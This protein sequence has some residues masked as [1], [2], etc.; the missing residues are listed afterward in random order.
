MVEI[1]I[2]VMVDQCR[3]VRSP[4][5]LGSS[6][7]KQ[8]AAW[9]R[10]R[11]AEKASID[12][13]SAV[14]SDAQQQHQPTAVSVDLSRAT[15]RDGGWAQVDRARQDLGRAYPQRYPLEPSCSMNH[16]PARERQRAASRRGLGHE[17]R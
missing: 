16:G 17:R 8:I 14:E 5:R 9:E 6:L 4:T 2:G 10:R 12:W 1:E 15:S 3:D 7:I 11:N 13:V